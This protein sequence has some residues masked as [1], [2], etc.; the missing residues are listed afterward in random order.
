MDADMSDIPSLAFNLV[1]AKPI[2]NTGVKQH[3]ATVGID[4]K[5]VVVLPQ[6][7]GTERVMFHFI[8]RLPNNSPS[9]PPTSHA[10]T[11]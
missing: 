10:R 4:V 6:F 7:A 9:A 8:F 3:T 5:T 2:I 11:E 1:F